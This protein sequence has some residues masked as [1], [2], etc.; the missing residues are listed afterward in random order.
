M[1]LACGTLSY[2]QESLLRALEGIAGA[3]FHWVEVG[4]VCG[5]CEH[6]TPETMGPAEADRLAHQ[7]AQFGLGIVS[8]AGHV[9]LKYPLLGKGA[10]IAATGF[11]LLRKRIDLAQ[12]LQVGIVNTGIG[13]AREAAELEAFYNDFDALL[14]YA[15]KRG[16]KIGLESHAGLTETA[17][18]SL[19]LCQRMGRPSL[20]VN[21]DAANVHYFTGLDPVDDLAAC[22][23]DIAA[24]LIHVHIKDHRGAKGVWDFP[25]LGKGNVN[26]AGLA[27]LL[28]R[29]DY[30]GPC[31]LEI[32]FRGP[33]SRDPAPEIID[34]GIRESHRFLKDLGLE[35]RPYTG[36]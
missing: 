19:A 28:R 20:G 15:E 13:V 10:D 8:I 27:A 7:V 35:D 24:W 16:V 30:G 17:Q 2:R 18:A 36:A 3:G 21:Y 11:H 23:G 5:Y 6:I 12:Q 25:P 22:A 31:S 33:D 4:C 32:E 29:M 34:E 9:D 14:G 26:L 1:I